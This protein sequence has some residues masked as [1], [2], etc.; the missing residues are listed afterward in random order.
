MWASA[1]DDCGGAPVCNETNLKKKLLVMLLLLMAVV[2]L[3]FVPQ[4]LAGMY[5]ILMV[6]LLLVLQFQY[7]QL[8]ALFLYFHTTAVV[9]V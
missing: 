7:C 8:T 2:V 5:L 1:T 6:L 9:P 3:L 4:V